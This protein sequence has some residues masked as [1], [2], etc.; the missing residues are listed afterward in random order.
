MTSSSDRDRAQ[1]AKVDSVSKRKKPKQIEK[2]MELPN[3]LIVGEDAFNGLLDKMI[4][5][6]PVPLEEMKRRRNPE[7]DPRYLPVFD[8]SR[9]I[10]IAKKCK[11]SS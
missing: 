2:P 4:Q 7:T 9:K 6:P 1:H 3:P 10:R 11:P 8:F 5:S